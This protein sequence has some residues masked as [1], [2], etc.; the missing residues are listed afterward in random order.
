MKELLT[1]AASALSLFLFP[2]S[3]CSCREKLSEAAA[4]F[5]EPCGQ[6][7]E[8][9]DPLFRC[10]KCFRALLT[11]EREI[12]PGC[13]KRRSPFH[14]VASVFDYLPPASLLV[15]KFKYSNAVYLAKGLGAFLALQLHTL[16]WPLP[17][18]IVPVPLSRARLFSRGYNQ[19]LLL[20]VA[21]SKIIQRPVE[22]VLIRTAWDYPQAKL[23]RQQRSVLPGSLFRLRSRT[24]IA[25][26]TL[27]II[28]DVL[29]TGSTLNGCAY[30]LLEGC[31]SSIYGLTVCSSQG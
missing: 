12:C 5:C 9:I 13:Q 24:D 21:L 19:S 1:G 28:D 14:G 16:Q 18:L 17:D 8:P 25:D 29:T 11:D 2:N 22:E 20:A 6:L 31:P 7:L 27:L 30:A 10:S 23:D 26:K 15:K 3:C 4:L